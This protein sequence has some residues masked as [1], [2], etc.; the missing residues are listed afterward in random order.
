MQQLRSPGSGLRRLI[1]GVAFA[2]GLTAAALPH[3]E[4]VNAAD[5]PATSASPDRG[6]DTATSAKAPAATAPGT[7]PQTATSPG[8][9]PRTPPADEDATDADSDSDSESTPDAKGRASAGNDAL[10]IEKGGKHIRI[11]G[12]GLGRDRYYDSFEQFINDAPLLAGLVFLIVLTVFLVPLLIIILLVW[13]KLRRNRLANET[14]LKLAERGVVPPAAAMEAVASGN[15]ASLAAAAEVSSPSTASEPAYDRARLV[16]RRAV[17]SDLRKGVVLTGVGLG[18]SFFS[19]LDDGSPN[20]IG[21]ICLFVGLG[22]C[23]LWFF[24]ERGTPPP[25]DPPGTPPTRGA[26]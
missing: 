10:V 17:W 6:K 1:L 19:M 14:L 15:A 16:R 12:L 7:K 20:S 3:V 9:T 23:L 21:L 18:L 26:S 25:R 22:Y 11:E 2:A 13:Y 24:E 5:L 8:A 4:R